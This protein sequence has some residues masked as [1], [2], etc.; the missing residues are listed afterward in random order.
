MGKLSLKAQLWLEQVSLFASLKTQSQDNQLGYP[1]L[2]DISFEVFEGERVAIVGPSGAGKTY[3]LRLLNRLSEPT[4]GKIYLQNQ[5]YS[6]IPVL[7]LR[8]I[9]TLVSQEPKL[10]GMTVKEA[11]AYPLVLRGLPKQTIQ[12]RVSHWIEQLQIPDEWLTRTEVQ[13]SLGQRQLVAIARALVIQPKILLLDEPT[14]ALDVNQAEHLVEIF[15]QLAQNYQTTVVMVNHQLELVEKFCTRLLCLQ[16]G[17]LLVNQ[18]ASE[19]SWLNLRD[20]LTQAKAQ[21]EFEI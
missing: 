13:L 3:L 19:I 18:E 6:Q 8:S 4:S 11:L 1:I 12:Q 17:R 5:E 2:Q 7:Q 9:V 15:S 16:Q 10:L 21:D 14:S 20:K